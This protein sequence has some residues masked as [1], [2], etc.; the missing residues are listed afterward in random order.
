MAGTLQDI[1]NKVRRITRSPTQNQ[2]P[3][4]EIDFQVN[5][6][7]LNDMPESLRIFA[8]R[9]SFSWQ[10]IPNIDT[11]NTD[12]T[13]AVDA[14]LDFNQRY[15]TVHQP[16]FIAGKP[17]YYSEDRGEFFGRYPMVQQITQIG[18]GDGVLAGPYT[19]TLPSIP[20]LQNQVLISSVDINNNALSA[21][22]V[23]TSVTT[24][25]LVDTQTGVIVGSINYITGVLSITFLVPPLNQQAINAMTVPYVAQQPSALL[26]FDDKFVLRQVPDQPYTINFDAYIRPTAL[27][28]AGDTPELQQWWK[29]IAYGAAKLIFE[30]RSDMESVQTILPE[31]ERQ[32]R[33]V[34]RRTIV[35]QTS[36]RTGSIYANQVEYTVAPWGPGD[37]S[38]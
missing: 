20:I 38:F 28:N 3:N 19:F 26:Y 21:T 15:I 22:D 36:R 30:D 1:R 4:T 10:C 37:Y 7:M 14:L 17:A 35:Q 16:I 6:F 27:I 12:G 24:G 11:Y 9:T 23:P 2:L 18:Q 5:D 34:N 29:Y 8:L 32:E 13:A 25:N 31:F 33:L